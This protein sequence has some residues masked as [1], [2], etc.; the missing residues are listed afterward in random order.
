MDLLTVTTETPVR[1]CK[2]LRPD[3]G[4]ALIDLD[5]SQPCPPHVCCCQASSTGA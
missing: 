4:I 5:R 3:I 2:V 1:L